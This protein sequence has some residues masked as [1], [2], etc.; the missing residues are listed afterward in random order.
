TAFASAAAHA[1]SATASRA[2]SSTLAGASVLV[3]GVKATSPGFIVA[4]SRIV[5][6][7][8]STTSAVSQPAR[9]R[10][11]TLP[12]SETVRRR[13]WRLSR[14]AGQ[15]TRPP[16]GRSSPWPKAAIRSARAARRLSQETGTDGLGVGRGD[17][18]GEED[19]LGGPL[20]P[21]RRLPLGDGPLATA[22]AVDGEVGA[23]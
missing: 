8:A 16:A 14:W 18:F 13:D 5:S 1:S 6:P 12:L 11:R 10:T 4:R 23:L 19:A 3:A 22:V 9:Q 15:W 7:R 17:G 20:D 2:T 21:H